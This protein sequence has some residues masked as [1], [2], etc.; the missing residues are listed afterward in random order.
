MKFAVQF[1]Q[2][3][4]FL[5]ITLSSTVVFSHAPVQCLLLLGREADRLR[6]PS[7]KTVN[8]WNCLLATVLN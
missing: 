5:F 6:P 2:G 4:I 8:V 1:S 7:A 3:R